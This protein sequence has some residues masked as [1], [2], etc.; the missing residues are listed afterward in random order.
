MQVLPAQDLSQNNQF[1]SKKHDL[2]TIVGI[3]N[4]W[5]YGMWHQLCICKDI[6]FG[7]KNMQIS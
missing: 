7:D 6:D 4:M 2:A 1:V 5:H 3:M